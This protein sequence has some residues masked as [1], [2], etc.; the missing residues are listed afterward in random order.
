MAL[1]AAL[2]Q[3]PEDPDA[4]LPVEATPPS[5]ITTP[6]KVFRY[7]AAYDS[8]ASASS[9]SRYECHKSNSSGVSSEGGDASAQ[10]ELLFTRGSQATSNGCRSIGRKLPLARRCSGQRRR[11]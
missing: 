9:N 7:T 10:D 6:V 5:E 3:A 8:R 4:L 11:W 2:A 1:A